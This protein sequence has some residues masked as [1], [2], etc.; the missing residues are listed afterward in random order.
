[1]L[2]TPALCC[3]STCLKLMYYQGKKT[4]GFISKMKVQI[5]DKSHQEVQLPHVA[6]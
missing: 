3:W 6:A 4:L 5:H 1:M 2:T